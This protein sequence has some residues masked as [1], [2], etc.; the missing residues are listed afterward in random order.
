M[1]LGTKGW[2]DGE[3][4]VGWDNLTLADTAPMAVALAIKAAISQEVK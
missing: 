1:R 2:D 4:E 3:R